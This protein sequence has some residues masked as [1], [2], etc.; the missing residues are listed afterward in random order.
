MA[1]R[2]AGWRVVNVPCGLGRPEQ[3]RRREAELREAARRSGF[4]LRMP[5]EP[6][7]I[8][9][10]DDRAAAEAALLQVAREAL[11][12]LAPKIVVSPSPHDRH[13]GHE[14]VARGVGAALAERGGA[15]PRWWMWA[16]WGSLRQPTLG[17]AFEQERLDEILAALGAYQ[18]ELERTDYCR[19]VRAR[20]EMTAALGSELL[21]GFGATA[22]GRVAY[23]EVL[24]EAALVDRRWML[25]PPRW[26]EPESPLAEPGGIE[27]VLG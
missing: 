9:L 26:L 10:G 25:G 16:L 14:L 22:P 6:V 19:V 13:H 3:H 5:G 2:D 24:T 27:A 21:F 4:E 12:E 18:G 7:A 1:L 8:S 15:A 17:T 11:A 23:A 20:A